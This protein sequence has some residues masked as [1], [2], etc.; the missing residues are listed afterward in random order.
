M[1]A[2][3]TNS[4]KPAL[5]AYSKLTVKFQPSPRNCDVFGHFHRSGLLIGQ[6]PVNFDVP[7]CSSDRR[8]SDCDG[9]YCLFHNTSVSDSDES[10]ISYIIR[11]ADSCKW[12]TVISDAYV[13]KE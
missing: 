3:R 6:Q 5:P 9:A 11:F 1:S 4:N 10:E 8:L 13:Y 12:V 7:E 2:A